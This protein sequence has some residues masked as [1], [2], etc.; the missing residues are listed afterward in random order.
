MQLDTAHHLYRALMAALAG[1]QE[2]EDPGARAEVAQMIS[3][4]HV[5][6]I[7]QRSDPIAAARLLEALDVAVPG[8]TTANIVGAGQIAER[9]RHVP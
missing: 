9:M 1:P 4:L 3:G 2:L 6:L 7:L 5:G 8:A